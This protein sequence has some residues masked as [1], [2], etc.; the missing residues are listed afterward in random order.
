MTSWRPAGAPAC[1]P[2]CITALFMFQKLT[3]WCQDIIQD[4]DAVATQR[5]L[6]SSLE[7]IWKSLLWKKRKDASPGAGWRMAPFSIWS[8]LSQCGRTC[9]SF[10]YN[11]ADDKIAYEKRQIAAVTLL[12]GPSTWHIKACE[13]F[14][15]FYFSAVFLVELDWYMEPLNISH[16]VLLWYE[17]TL[18]EMCIIL[19]SY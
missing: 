12:G 17:V 7:N 11:R 18:S 4:A 13:G 2:E 19:C 8:S 9:V 5:L 6:P 10:Q 1:Q 3:W 15:L 16:D 14:F